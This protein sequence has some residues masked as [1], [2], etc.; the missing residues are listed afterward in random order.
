MVPGLRKYSCDVSLDP[1]S[2]HRR[3]LLSENHRTVTLVK[4]RQ[5]YPDHEDR[6]MNWTQ[7]LSCTGLSGR[8]YWEVDWSGEADIGVSYEEISRSKE[9]RDCVFGDNDH[10]WSLRIYDDGEYCVSHNRSSTRLPRSC[11]SERGGVFSGKG[12][13]YS[14]NGGKSPING[15]VS[16][17]KGGMSHINGG[18][19]SGKGGTFFGRVGV[20]LDSEA[21][22]LSFYDVSSDELF[23]IWTFSS[24]FS[25]PLFPGF[26]L[27][28]EGSSV[29][30]VKEKD[31]T[32]E[33]LDLTH[34]E[35]TATRT[36]DKEK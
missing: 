13:M 36:K 7:V 16:S 17:G 12:G 30:L 9:E 31:K 33:K 20:F 5:K 29:T 3:L 6:F 32:E 26:G 23:H 28:K 34:D 4:K 35:D 19:S 27:D 14:V 25:K 15:G 22:T 21:G 18:V 10:S 2:A 1:N 11:H 24:S 8:C